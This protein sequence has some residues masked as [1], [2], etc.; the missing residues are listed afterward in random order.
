MLADKDRDELKSLKAPTEPNVHVEA[1]YREAPS[2]CYLRISSTGLG[3][4][5][6]HACNTS[7]LGEWW[8]GDRQV[9]VIV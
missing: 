5:F 2:R 6:D 3:R 1:S 7:K 9:G 8:G 4:K